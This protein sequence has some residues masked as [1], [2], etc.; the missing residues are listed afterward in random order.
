[1]KQYE[2]TMQ[3]E[4]DLRLYGRDWEP[5]DAP[6]GLLCLVHGLGEHS[7]WYEHVAAHL[8]A[9]DY[10]LLAYD[11]R[12]HGR[13]EGRRGHSPSYETTMND[14]GRLLAEAEARYPGSPRYL[15][16]HSLGGSLVINCA[17]R[18]WPAM[19]IAGW[20]QRL[21]G[22]LYDRWSD[23]QV[24]NGLDITGISHDPEVLAA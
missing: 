20:K 6:K 4:D 10:A 9:A 24:S 5:D 23:L 12:G 7:G 11:Q 13:S 14:I 3:A 8:N 1:M 19:P 21:M 17:L 15:Y 2:F 16:G 18:C 22:S